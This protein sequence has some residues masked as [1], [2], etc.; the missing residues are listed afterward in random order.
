MGWGLLIGLWICAG[1]D[2]VPADTARFRAALPELVVE[3]VRLPL[4]RWR[5]PASVYVF[6]P[7]P[8]QGRSGSSIGE[9]LIG[10]PGLMVHNL[11]NAAQNERLAIRGAGARAAFGIRGIQVWLDGVPLTL[12][13]GQT[14]IEHLDPAEV[15]SVELVRGPVAALY[16][17]AASGVLS[18]RT[19]PEE[20]SAHRELEGSS[21]AYGWTRL[22]G[23]AWTA[24]SR[25]RFG[26]AASWVRSRGHR[27]GSAWERYTA[28]VWAHSG[29]D[30][31]GRWTLRLSLLDTP[32]AGDPGGLTRLQAEADPRAADPAALRF[33]AG[34]SVTQ[35]LGSVRYQRLQGQGAELRIGVYALVRRFANRLPFESG[36][37]GELN[38]LAWGAY[39]QYRRTYAVS[40]TGRLRPFLGLDLARGRDDRRRFDNRSDGDLGPLRLDQCEEVGLLGFYGGLEGYL[41]PWTFR[42]ALRGD[43]QPFRLRD[44]FA[45]DGDDSG[46]RRFRAWSLMAAMGRDLGAGLTAYVQLGTGFDTPTFTELAHPSAQGGMNPDLRPQR[47]VGLDVGVKGQPR[48]WASLECVLF[49]TYLWDELLPFERAEMPGRRFYRNV[50]RS[51]RRGL[52]V[53]LQVDLPAAWVLR[54][55]ATELEARFRRDP[56]EASWLFT[57]GLP[58]RELYVA[59]GR[60]IESGIWFR[61][62]LRHVGEQYADEANRERVRAYTLIDMAA[63]AGWRRGGIRMRPFLVL[64]NLLN[65]LYYANVR[66]NAAGARYYE[67][68]PGRYAIF[69]VRLE[70]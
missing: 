42:L 67:P 15:R 24:A 65:R 47:S 5:A 61:C 68:G 30:T 44:R 25:G 49:R 12:P 27:Q 66:P 7:H 56:G 19:E 64:H 4:E 40:A 70:L 41:P 63:G 48:P 26:M 29:F 54:L 36:G 6:R 11:F 31:T 46:R 17:N 33:R 55:V 18:L 10:L 53:A 1:A 62:A 9:L 57:P 58:R 38:R 23:R 59:L 69:G 8:A 43:E 60:E 37:A 35:L 3:A 32:W 50:G 2:T 13:D 21:G 34:E 52:E 28:T 39:L 45:L 51:E 16:G 14:A 20:A 22:G